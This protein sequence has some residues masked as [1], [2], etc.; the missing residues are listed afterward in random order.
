MNRALIILIALSILG[1]AIA[2][3]GAIFRFNAFGVGPEGYS[4]ACTN[5]ALI[6]IALAVCFNKEPSDNK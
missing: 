1:F 5:L 6:A 2:V 4:N 3:L